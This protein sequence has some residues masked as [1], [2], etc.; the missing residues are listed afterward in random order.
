MV[1]ILHAS[2][3]WAWAHPKAWEHI[4]HAAGCSWVGRQMR[5]G[6]SANKERE[7]VNQLMSHCWIW[8]YT[9][10]N[11]RILVPKSWTLCKSKHYGIKVEYIYF[12]Q[13]FLKYFL[14]KQNQ[15]IIELISSHFIIIICCSASKRLKSISPLP[16]LSPCHYPTLVS[17]LLR[18]LWASGG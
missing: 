13:Q 16:P 6:R 10:W 17:S 8:F 4:L 2:N 7:Y 18:E 5:E 3:V 9:N 15:P 11:K 12:K 14:R 1:R